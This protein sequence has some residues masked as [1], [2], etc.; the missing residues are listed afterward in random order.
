MLSIGNMPEI[1]E[2]TIPTISTV[3]LDHEGLIRSACSLLARIMVGEPV[4]REPTMIGP[5]EV[6]ERESTN[7]LATTDAAVAAALR[8]IRTHL[9]QDLSVEM[10]AGQV[11][12]SGRQ[13]VRRFQKALHRS[14]TEEILR[15]RLAETK[16]MLRSTD[17]QIIDI[18][19]KVGFHSTT[20]LHRT[21]RRAFGQTPEEY[22]RAGR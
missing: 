14:V 22:R 6:V 2:S 13:L 1:C 5:R 16:R 12:L 3:E 15:Q 11:G 7:V 9:R 17:I 8:Y 10:L 19:P 4:P 20:Y 21:F 18:A